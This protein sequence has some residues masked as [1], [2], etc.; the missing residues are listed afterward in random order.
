M[1]RT[2]G[3]P[4]SETLG[5]SQLWLAEAAHRSLGYDLCRLLCVRLTLPAVSALLILSPGFLTSLDPLAGG[6]GCER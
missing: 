5:V 3:L 1:L 2:T 6:G 4:P